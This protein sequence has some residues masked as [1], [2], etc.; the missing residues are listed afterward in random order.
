MIVDEYTMRAAVH[1]KP[2]YDV[3]YFLTNYDRKVGASSHKYQ[4]VMWIDRPNQK[5][6]GSIALQY[7]SKT[8]LKRDYD[9][10]K[11]PA[12]DTHSRA[13]GRLF[14]VL[15]HPDI[16]DIEYHAVR[17]LVHLLKQA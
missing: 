13:F 7:Q 15:F 4:S 6:D 11:T 1:K 12:T 8:V 5:G 17:M 9:W 10:E 3:F 2:E 14:T 16:T